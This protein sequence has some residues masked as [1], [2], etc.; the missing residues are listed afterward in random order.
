MV[1]IIKKNI[2]FKYLKNEKISFIK[3]ILKLEYLFTQTNK[4]KWSNRRKKNTPYNKNTLTCRY[5][6][7]SHHIKI[8]EGLCYF[9]SSCTSRIKF[10]NKKLTL[11][12]IND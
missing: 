2:R 12:F 7:G 10:D 5:S 9:N 1:I 4:K 3:V 6:L 11:R 8:I